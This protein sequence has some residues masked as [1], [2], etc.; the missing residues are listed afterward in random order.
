MKENFNCQRKNNVNQGVLHNYR[1]ILEGIIRFEHEKSILFELR[2]NKESYISFKIKKI[3]A[4]IKSITFNEWQIKKENF[5]NKLKI[6]EIGRVP[7]RS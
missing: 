7:W 1:L 4:D 3:V 6:N 2:K 5:Y